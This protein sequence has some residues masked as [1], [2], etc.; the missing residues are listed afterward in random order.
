MKLQIL[1]R[2]IDPDSS[3]LTEIRF[4]SKVNDC[5]VFLNSNYQ[6]QKKTDRQI[7][8]HDCVLIAHK[9]NLVLEGI[10]TID[11]NKILVSTF[12]YVFRVILVTLIRI[13]KFHV[14][15]SYKIEL[16]KLCGTVDPLI[17]KVDQ[18]VAQKEKE[19]CLNVNGDINFCNTNWDQL[20]SSDITEKFL[21]KK[22]THLNIVSLLQTSSLL[23][24]FFLQ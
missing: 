14:N 11:T 19:N 22:F 24:I 8:K 3:R 5:K 2:K 18:Y 16:S 20:T 10:K 21:L 7:G 23:E 15:S 17:G 9:S 6:L 1:L 13:L 12:V 4:D